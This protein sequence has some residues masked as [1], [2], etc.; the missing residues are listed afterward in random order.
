[1]STV[2]T[3]STRSNA[4][5]ALGKIC[6]KCVAL[7]KELITEN[8]DGTY[9]FDEDRIEE[10]MTTQEWQEVYGSTG[11]GI[12]DETIAEPVEE[13]HSVTEAE[14]TEHRAEVKPT[15]KAPKAKKVTEVVEKKPHGNNSAALK[16]S[17]KLNREIRCITTGEVWPNAYRMWKQNPGFMTSAQQDGLTKKL[18]EAA[19]KGYLEIVI[20]N[21]LHFQ[22]TTLPA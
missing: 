8:E 6:V 22:L 18:Y 2:K 7:A 5:R 3:Y 17:L 10:L 1:M 13:F 21:E 14:H 20:I 19:K 9:S 4:R 12:P 15:K 16:S 11:K